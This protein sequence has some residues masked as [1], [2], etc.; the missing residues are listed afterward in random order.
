MYVFINS[1]TYPYK[2]LKMKVLVADDKADLRYVIT[3]A[4]Q[5]IRQDVEVIEC[6]NG[7]EAVEKYREHNP[8]LVFMDMMMPEMDG[9]NAILTIL[10][11]EPSAKRKIVII[12]AFAREERIKIL[13]EN[14]SARLVINKPPDLKEII[15]ALMILDEV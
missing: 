6:V 11:G 13:L 1:Y 2:R 4:I 7:L 9:Y 12:S 10:E 15:D 8:E 14:K 3:Q 5:S